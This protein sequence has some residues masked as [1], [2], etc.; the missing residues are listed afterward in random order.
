[1]AKPAESSR[2]QEAGPPSPGP[3]RRVGRMTAARMLRE[4]LT[5]RLTAAHFARDAEAKVFLAATH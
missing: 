4:R 2:R 3:T 5:P 1:M